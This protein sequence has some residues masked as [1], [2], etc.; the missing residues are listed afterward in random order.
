MES[1]MKIQRAKSKN[2]FT[3]MPLLTFKASVPVLEAKPKSINPLFLMAHLGQ[4]QALPYR[5]N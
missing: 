4:F 3:R 1:P 2:R 5:P